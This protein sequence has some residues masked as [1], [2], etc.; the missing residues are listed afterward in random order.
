MHR[1]SLSNEERDL[2]CRLDR[3]RDANVKLVDRDIGRR[4]LVVGKCAGDFENV[5]KGLALVVEFDARVAEL[6]DDALDA[7]CAGWTELRRGRHCD[8]FLVARD[9]TIRVD[10]RA[11]VPL[12]DLAN[13]SKSN[14]F[15]ASERALLQIAGLR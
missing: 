5:Y 13:V 1:R 10:D 2:A 9:L 4:W 11:L 3:G 7:G 12:R 15:Q 6:R 14:G 8:V